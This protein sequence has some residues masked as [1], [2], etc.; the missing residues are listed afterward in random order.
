MP[1][2]IS[3][4]CKLQPL[5]RQTECYGLSL[6]QFGGCCSF[7]ANSTLSEIVGPVWCPGSPPVQLACALQGV[8]LDRQILICVFCSVLP[9]LQVKT[10]HCAKQT[11]EEQSQGGSVNLSKLQD[12]FFFL[13]V[14]QHNITIASSQHRCLQDVILPKTRGNKT[15]EVLQLSLL[16]LFFH[17]LSKLCI[18]FFSL[19]PCFDHMLS[20]PLAFF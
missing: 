13:C 19:S 3:Q 20:W 10:K 11:H 18:F 4:Y 9:A 15:N 1:M 14:S 6:R 2:G 12:P 16:C 17:D 7:N 5:W 8:A